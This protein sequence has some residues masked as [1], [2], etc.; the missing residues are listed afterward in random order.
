MERERITSN[1]RLDDSVDGEVWEKT[2]ATGQRKG[3]N[4][5]MEKG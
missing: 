2:G 3:R 4:M 5:G 1:S